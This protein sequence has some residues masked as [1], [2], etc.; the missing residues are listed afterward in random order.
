ML[1]AC[2][3]FAQS[4]IPRATRPVIT[5]AELRRLLQIGGQDRHFS[6]PGNN[7]RAA[8]KSTAGDSDSE[9]AEHEQVQA[10]D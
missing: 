8:G 10:T 1:A 4:V 3:R 2:N 9:Q 5:Q 7:G 6:G